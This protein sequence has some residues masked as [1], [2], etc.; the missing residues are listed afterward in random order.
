MLLSVDS[1][2]PKLTAAPCSQGCSLLLC[3]QL[4]SALCAV[5]DASGPDTY[6]ESSSESC[7]SPSSPHHHGGVESFDSDDDNERNHKG[8]NTPNLPPLTC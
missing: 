3:H 6:G 2:G 5:A 1:L 7:S 4:L 8:T